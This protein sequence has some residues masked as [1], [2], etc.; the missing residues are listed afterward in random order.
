[1]PM[2]LSVV[3]AATFAT[4]GLVACGGG[5]SGGESTPVTAPVPAPPPATAEGV[6]GGTLTGSTSPDFQLLVLE[7]GDFYTLYGTNTSASFVV[8]GLIQGSGTSANNRFTS[9]NAA[10][11]GFSPAIPLTIDSTYASE[12]KIISGTAT[13]ARNQ[14]RFSGGP[15]PNSQYVYE[16]RAQLPAVAGNWSTTALDGSNV[17]LAVSTSGTFT[18]SSGGCT[19]SGTILPRPS[20]KNV[21]DVALRF[22][23][24]PCA[25]AGQSGAG[26]A[27]VSPVSGGRAQLIVAATNTSRT[28]G[29][30]IFGTR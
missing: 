11:F 22:G 27:L 23:A 10:D 12:S 26:L 9:S 30:V 7:N 3:V 5:G 6:Y 21:F 1:M 13:S 19:F 14:V 4:L 29:T 18:A 17:Q 2:K 24:A 15:I 20:G 25:L 28:S 8:A 16:S